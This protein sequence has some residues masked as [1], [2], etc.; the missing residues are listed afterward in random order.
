MRTDYH[1]A[2]Y[3]VAPR[4]TP[5]SSAQVDRATAEHIAKEEAKAYFAAIKGE[6]GREEQLKAESMGRYGIVEARWERNGRMHYHDLI[7]DARG[8]REFTGHTPPGKLRIEDHD[9]DSLINALNVAAREFDF[10]ARTMLL[11]GPGA[12]D[13]RERL[14]QT[15]EQQAAEARAFAEAADKYRTVTFHY[16][17]ATVE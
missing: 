3:H 2:H 12:L 8:E 4:Y 6:G 17:H 16:N 13:A 5:S 10:C 9:V 14:C 11:E 7:T 1:N 15:F